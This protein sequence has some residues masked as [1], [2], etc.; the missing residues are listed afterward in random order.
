MKFTNDD[1]E[2]FKKSLS[3]E[4]KIIDSSDEEHNKTM[5]S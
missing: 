5:D 1:V 3:N 4:E 2:K